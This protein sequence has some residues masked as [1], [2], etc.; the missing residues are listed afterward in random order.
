MSRESA[1]PSHRRLLALLKRAAA[2][3]A[4]LT[5]LAATPHARGAYTAPS[6][7]RTTGPGGRGPICVR[8]TTATRRPR[9]D[10]GVHL[11]AECPSA[12]TTTATHRHGLPGD[13]ERVTTRDRPANSTTEPY[14]YWFVASGPSPR[15]R[16]TVNGDQATARPIAAVAARRPA[17]HRGSP[18]TAS[19]S[20][21]AASA[22]DHPWPP[23]TPQR[24]RSLAT[25]IATSANVHRLTPPPRHVHGPGPGTAG[26]IPDR[27][28]HR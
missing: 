28:R 9:L 1:L 6:A 12:A 17:G 27:E 24:R 20:A 4:V 23:P 2:A 7:A 13:G 14:S 18:P 15:R 25:G 8:N 11:P 22:V 16:L 19:R 10:P 3:L 21:D 5:G 26:A